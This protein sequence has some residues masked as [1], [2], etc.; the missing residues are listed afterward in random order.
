M[1]PWFHCA[2]PLGRLLLQ[3][4]GDALS[5]LRFDDA[6]RTDPGTRAI[7]ARAPAV[8]REAA[9]Q[10]DAYWCGE[11]R[12][13]ALPLQPAGSEFAQRVW[14]ALEGVGYAQRI[15]Y[16]ALAAAVGLGCGHARAVGR[17]VGAN[18]LLVVLPCHR[19]VA[20][21]GALRGYAGGVAR[22]RALLELEALSAGTAPPPRAAPTRSTSARTTP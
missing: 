14:H 15:G 12:V 16:A 2:S 8:L 13:F 22:K 20:S 3:A 10:L 17:A 21:D 5:A 18:P 9:R 4:Q 7:D 1:S 19:V 11:R 6:R